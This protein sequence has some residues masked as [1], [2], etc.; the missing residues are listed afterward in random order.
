MGELQRDW[1]NR[2]FYENC[3]SEYEQKKV[4]PTDIVTPANSVYG[5]QGGGQTTDRVFLLDETEAER[6]KTLLLLKNNQKSWW[7]RT[8]GKAADSAA[9]VS[10]D[11]T[12]MRYGYTADSMDIAVRPAV[13]VTFN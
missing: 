3:F 7:L 6:Y 4:L 2:T 1:L 8:P 5:T 10:A 9:F 13:W 11:G 12:V